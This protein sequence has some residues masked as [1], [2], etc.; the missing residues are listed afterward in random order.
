MSRKRHWKA[1]LAEAAAAVPRRTAKG[2]LAEGVALMRTMVD[3]RRLNN[4]LV[5][6]A[7]QWVAAVEA[8][9]FPDLTEKLPAQSQTMA[10]R[11]REALELALAE[12]GGNRRKVAELLGVGERTV[13]RML[14]R[15]G[16]LSAG[17]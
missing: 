5:F 10:E 3:T 16:L 13:Y 6:K 12:A 2:L 8:S 4:D 14:E 7:G 11:E 1:A 9:D 15:H 17:K